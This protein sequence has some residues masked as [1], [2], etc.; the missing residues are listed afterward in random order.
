MS[1]DLAVPASDAAGQWNRRA[2]SDD[3]AFF[4]PS[5]TI[6]VKDKVVGPLCNLRNLPGHRVVLAAVDEEKL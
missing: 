5:P 3:T 1:A 2:S 6:M 4:V